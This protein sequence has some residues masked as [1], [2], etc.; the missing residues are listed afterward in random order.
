MKLYIFTF[1]LLIFSK[2]AGQKKEYPSVK[3]GDFPEGIYMTLEDVL[4]KTPSSKEEVYFKSSAE[5]DS[6]HLPEKVFFYNKQNNQK[7][8]KPLGVSYK[9]EM[10][11]QT[12][13][14]YTHSED[15]SYEANVSSRF[16]KVLYYGRFLYFEESLRNIW[17]SG[18]LSELNSRTHL[19]SGSNKGIILDLKNK[20]FNI[21]QNC[22]DLNDFLFE[23]E[24]PSIE[25]DPGKFTLED[26]HKKIEE[27]N[28][29]YM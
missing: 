15:K 1:F 5:H 23:H 11:F 12:Y 9:G 2:A 16:C 14:K 24:I 18:I 3:K 28:K 19:M 4:N 29:P 20:E 7:L 22:D 6:I 27:I 25:C 8:R 10:Y 13:R 17:T 26:V 21:L